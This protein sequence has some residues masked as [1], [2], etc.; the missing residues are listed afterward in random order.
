[1][2][3]AHDRRKQSRIAATNERRMFF[4]KKLNGKS[5]LLRPTSAVLG[6]FSLFWGAMAGTMSDRMFTVGSRKDP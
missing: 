4:I 1:M 3:R 2:G 6:W 5:I